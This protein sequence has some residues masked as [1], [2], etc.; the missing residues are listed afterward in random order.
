M[1]LMSRVERHKGKQGKES[2]VLPLVGVG[3]VW[4]TML[5]FLIR[6]LQIPESLAFRQ[7]LQISL[8]FCSIL[9]LALYLLSFIFVSTKN[10]AH[11]DKVTRVNHYIVILWVLCLTYHFILWL[12][13]GSLLSYYYYGG[14]AVTWGVLLLTLLHFYYYFLFVRTERKAQSM[15]N[16]IEIRR[17]SY[18]SMR[19][20][21]MMY[22]LVHELMKRDAEV[23]QMLRW[24]HFD[25]KMERVVWE[26]E[27]YIHATSFTK[28]EL[29]HLSGIEA[30]MD[31]L[32]VII[33]QH[34]LHHDLYKKLEA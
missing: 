10:F 9:F 13:N 2:V 7:T 19:R 21:L 30:W 23:R 14:L 8:F 11:E 20:I 27:P 4:I 18:E 22:Q 17:Q 26:M 32:L 5:F 12:S 29:D 31:N 1:E 34:P 16:R 24:N 28:E 3:M 6:Y 25:V 15:A 33:E